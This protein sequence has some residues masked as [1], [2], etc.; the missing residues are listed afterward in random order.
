M[1]INIFTNLF[2]FLFKEHLPEWQLRR[3]GG[4]I[5][6]LKKNT[7]LPKFVNYNKYTE[8]GTGVDF[9]LDLSVWD[10]RS[11]TILKHRS[12]DPLFLS[13]SSYKSCEPPR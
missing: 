9:F 3:F 8:C 10:D 12:G 5:K 6:N 7:K 2:V 4:F 11:R 13:R 1:K